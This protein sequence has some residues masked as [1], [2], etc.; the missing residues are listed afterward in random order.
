MDSH[1]RTSSYKQVINELVL[2]FDE[3][4][5]QIDLRNNETIK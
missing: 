5:S 1:I 2:L 3:A 4:E